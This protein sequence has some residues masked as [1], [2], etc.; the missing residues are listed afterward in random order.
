MGALE[1]GRDGNMKD[2]VGTESGRAPNKLTETEGYFG[3]RLKWFRK[4]SK[5]SAKMTTAKTP[6]NCR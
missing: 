6:N 2:Q 3:V 4:N 1:A 5:K